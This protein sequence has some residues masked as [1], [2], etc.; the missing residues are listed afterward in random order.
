MA[1]LTN[2]FSSRRGSLTTAVLLAVVL[3]CAERVVSLGVLAWFG[4]GRVKIL[5]DTIFLQARANALW[6]FSLPLAKNFIY[7][8][9]GFALIGAFL[10]Y[11]KYFWRQGFLSALAFGLIL[12]GAASN[13]WTRAASGFVWDWFNVSLFGSVGSWNLADALLLGGMMIWLWLLWKEK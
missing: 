9:S 8:F 7:I 13:L 3:F 11:L 2:F 6:V 10:V 12:S 5:G 1:A 4:A